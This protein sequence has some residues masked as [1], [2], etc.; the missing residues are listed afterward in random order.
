MF[1]PQEFEALGLSVQVALWCVGVT[2]VPGVWLGW[3][4]ARREF[5]GK[6]MVDA[7]VHLPLVLP[8]VVVGYLLLFMLGQGSAL[9]GWLYQTLGLEIAFTMKAAVI[10]AAVMGFPLMVRAVRLSMEAVDP[11]LGASPLRAWFTVTLP[12]ALPGIITGMVLAFARSLGE[13]GATIVFAGNLSGETRTLPLAIYS[14]T[15]MRDGEAAAMRLVILSVLLSF[16]ALLVSEVVSRRTRR[17][18]ERV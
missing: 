3:L 1:T 7:V 13:F 14:F 11:R 8:P 2:L 9:G 16:A 4:L 6:V 5:P 17:V 12:L 18:M 15:Q 10:A